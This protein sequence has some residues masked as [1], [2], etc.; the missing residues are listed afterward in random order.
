MSTILL[1][2]IVATQ[3][4]GL[5]AFTLQDVF[6]NLVLLSVLSIGGSLPTM[7]IL[8][9]LRLMGHKSWFSFLLSTISLF[10]SIGLVWSS[11]PHKTISYD[12]L[13][14]GLF[15][16]PNCGTISPTALCLQGFSDVWKPGP[17]FTEGDTDSLYSTLY[18]RTYAAFG[19]SL[20]FWLGLLLD[21]F[22]QLDVETIEKKIFKRSSTPTEH[23]EREYGAITRRQWILLS[24]RFLDFLGCFGTIYIISL[25]LQSLVRFGIGSR[26]WTFGQI[27]ALTIWVPPIAQYCYLQLNGTEGN[28]WHLPKTLTVT[29]HNT[30]GRSTSY[31]GSE[32]DQQRSSTESNN[33]NAT[34]RSNSRPTSDMSHTKVPAQR[35]SSRTSDC[36]GGVTDDDQGSG[37]NQPW[38]R[39]KSSFSH[40][41]DYNV[42]HG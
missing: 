9:K 23:T 39:E 34:P 1:A 36:A 14:Q 7:F 16:I 37:H 17:G 24:W 3:A 25:Y 27:V 38:I 8:F 42:G 31:D 15:S 2:A 18:F 4:G 6:T 32:H 5:G 26:E 28:R 22:V 13:E 12:Q 40:L 10:L 30:V 41:H 29:R 35:Y 19:L 11:G 21:R 20:V 33:L